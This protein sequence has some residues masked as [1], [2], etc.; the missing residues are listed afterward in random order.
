MQYDPVT[1]KIKHQQKGRHIEIDKRIAY[2]QA[3]H[4]AAIYL[5]NKQRQLPSVY[6]QIIVNHLDKEVQF[7]DRFTHPRGKYVAT[8]EGGRLIQSLPL[9]FADATQYFSVSQQEEYRR[10]FEADVINMLAGSIAEAK[11]VAIRD[12]ELFN[13]NLINLNA[14]HFY[15]GD[16]DL[17]VITDYMR[18]FIADRSERNHK[19]AELFTAAFRFVNKRSHWHSIKALAGFILD[20]AKDAVNCEEVIAFLEARLVTSVAIA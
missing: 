9:S 12:D 3:G 5:N 15:G 14:L 7:D 17:E 2:H 10:A 19:L 18:C 13:P 1:T 20:D 16:S 11:Y 6:F 8:I 4:A